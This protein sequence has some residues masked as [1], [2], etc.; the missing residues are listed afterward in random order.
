MRRYN[1]FDELRRMQEQMDAL[2]DSFFGINNPKLTSS[3]LLPTNNTVTEY[4]K[5]LI[6]TW[7][8]DKELIATL[9]MPGVDKKDINIELIDNGLEIKVEKKTE[10]KHKDKK[11][12]VTSYEKSFAG[13]YEFIP[14]PK[15]IDTSK[16]TASY[17]N[18]VLE[19]RMPKIKSKKNSKKIQVN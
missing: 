8:T 19:L 2:F 16:I 12:G 10:A 1:I 3:N 5:P 6:D 11:T 14:T 9:E 7:E 17:K 13:Y 15:N 18:G 4:R